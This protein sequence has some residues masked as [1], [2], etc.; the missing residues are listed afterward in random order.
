MARNKTLSD[1]QLKALEML[2]S[3]KGYTYKAIAKEVGVDVHTIWDWRKSPAFPHF[4]ERL[5]ELND[6]K[7]EATVEAARQAAL[8][9]CL[10]KN[11]KLV[12]F[13]LKNEGYNPA[14]NIKADVPDE[15]VISI[16]NKDGKN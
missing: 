13:V 3:G 12:E 4:Q 5:K 16:G 6:E 9:L 1:K 14:T 8:D 11:P 10:E 15:I 7:W 2:S